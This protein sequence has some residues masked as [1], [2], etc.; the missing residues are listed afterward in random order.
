VCWG[1]QERERLINC[2]GKEWEKII[3]NWGKLSIRISD[4]YVVLNFHFILTCE[5]S[6]WCSNSSATH[7]FSKLWNTSWID[8]AN[9]NNNGLLHNVGFCSQILISKN[10]FYWIFFFSYPFFIKV[11]A[12]INF[13]AKNSSGLYFHIPQFF[14]LIFKSCSS[15][16]SWSSSTFFCFLT[17]CLN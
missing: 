5:N 11:F 7:E 8:I 1:V 15:C 13:A 4:I 3:E 17:Y 6:C 2:G 10:Y 14:I 16:I 9:K 12:I